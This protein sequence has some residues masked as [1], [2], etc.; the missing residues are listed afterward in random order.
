MPAVF[1]ISVLSCAV[2]G[3]SWN[4]LLQFFYQFLALSVFSF[5][6][7][8]LLK[9]NEIPSAEKIWLFPFVC[10][11]SAV[12]WSFSPLKNLLSWELINF[13]SGA[14]VFF[15]SFFLK[16]EIEERKKIIFFIFSLIILAGFW[17]F[18]YS[19]E[20]YSTL[21]NSNTLAFYSILAGGL[22]LKL[23]N[24]YLALAF[25]I[26][27]LVSKS[28]GAIIAVFCA[29]L[30]YAFDRKAFFEIKTNKFLFLA[31]FIMI[32]VSLLSIDPSSI[33]DR[34]NWWKSALLMIKES[35]LYG[36][37]T[38]A[39][40]YVSGAFAGKESLKSVYAHNHYL[41]FA[42][43]NGIITALIWFYFLIF[44]VKK[45][46]GFLR[47]A[48]FAAL[49]HSFFDFGMSSPYGFWLFC[50]C[51]GLSSEFS[52]LK[53][54]ES[55]FAGA[56]AVLFFLS[57][58][59]FY[60]G[61]YNYKKERLLTKASEDPSYFKKVIE[62]KEKNPYDYDYLS[63]AAKTFLKQAEEKKDF[64]LLAESAKTY[65]QKLIIN[66]WNPSDYLV[67][68]RIYSFMKEEDIKEELNKRAKKYLK[69]NEKDKI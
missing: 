27:I 69:A 31:V 13:L 29:A 14:A 41:E 22:S 42:A 36:W 5:V 23:G 7:L 52:S 55:F 8:K 47:Y 6:F 28:V 26:L 44:T 24:Y 60:G 11:L 33:R 51:A 59:F 21:K 46:Y 9:K 48:L 20:T 32:F 19:D 30:L 18:F 49:I 16:K 1:L 35:P 25:G 17:Q 43:E 65:E 58:S 40:A 57:V 68:E 53:T 50:F 54:K 56:S 2:F 10:A 66:P 63:F 45:S 3:N 64:S 39:F 37:G 34:L 67:L 12:S 38:G 62:E 61:I 15:S 4:F